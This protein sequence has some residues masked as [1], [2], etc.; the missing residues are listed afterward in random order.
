MKCDVALVLQFDGGNNFLTI[1]I[2]A[3]SHKC[4]LFDSNGYEGINAYLSE[5]DI[6]KCNNYLT[7]LCH[8]NPIVN[9]SVLSLHYQHPFTLN[10][11]VDTDDQFTYNDV[12]YLLYQH[13]Q[14][15]LVTEKN[16]TLC[17]HRFNWS[18]SNLCTRFKCCAVRRY[19]YTTELESLRFCSVCAIMLGCHLFNFKYSGNDS[20]ESRCCNVYCPSIIRVGT[21]LVLVK[22]DT[23]VQINDASVDDNDDKGNDDSDDNGTPILPILPVGCKSC[24]SL[25][26]IMNF[27][28]SS[29]F[30]DTYKFNKNLLCYICHKKA[31]SQCYNDDSKSVGAVC[32]MHLLELESSISIRSRLIRPL[33]LTCQY[34]YDQQNEYELCDRN[35]SVEVRYRT[36]QLCRKRLCESHY[37]IFQTRFTNSQKQKGLEGSIQTKIFK[38]SYKKIKHAS[39]PHK[40]C[41][42]CKLVQASYGLVLINFD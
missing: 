20:S 18:K 19:A 30:V 31:T 7:Y 11:V 40:C 12:K 41:Y 15:E 25:E 24:I 42:N 27:K 16:D 33:E 8:T 34:Q 2:Q 37:P 23:S 26:G 29:D 9:V 10:W 39:Q 5:M 21:E 28:I 17:T 38:Q 13:E 35:A 4:V 22:L 1:Y 36:N 3:S 14:H 6:K 32:K